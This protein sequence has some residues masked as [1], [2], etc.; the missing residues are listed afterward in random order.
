M[1]LK[2]VETNMK[3]HQ[4][5]FSSPVTSMVVELSSLYI[6]AYEFCHQYGTSLRL[7][8]LGV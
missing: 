3:Y 2:H 8:S 5:V 1:W 7:N 6:L 4:Y